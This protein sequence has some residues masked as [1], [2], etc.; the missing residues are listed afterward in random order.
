MAWKGQRDNAMITDLCETIKQLL[1]KK[2]AF[3]PAELVDIG[4]GPLGEK[5]YGKCS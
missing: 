3:D 4:L 5:N 1:I 2:G